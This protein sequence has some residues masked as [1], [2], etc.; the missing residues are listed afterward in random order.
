MNSN[1]NGQ[2]GN[3][4]QLGGSNMMDSLKNNLMTM[5]MFKNMNHTEA[6][7][8]NDMWVMLY[9]FIASQFVDFV[10]KCIP[11]LGT[12]AH[13]MYLNKLEGLKQISSIAI[14]DIIDNKTKTSSITIKI[15]INDG[16]NII[17]QSLLDYITNNKQTSHIGYINKNF[18]LNEMGVIAISEDVYAVM[19]E[20]NVTEENEVEKGSSQR[21]E[22]YSFNKDGTEL[23][24]FLENIKN[25]YVI[26]MNNKL[27]N[28]RYYFNLHPCNAVVSIE[29][30]KDYSRLPSDFVFVMKKFQTNRKFSNIFGEDIDII[31]KRVRFFLKNKDWYDKKG[32]PYTLGLLLS[33]SPGTGKTSTI[34]C[35]TNE[36]N[37]HIINVNLNNDITKTQLDNLFYNENINVINME[38]KQNESYCIPFD[39]RIYV[40]EDVDCQSDIVKQRVEAPHINH[41]YMPTDDDKPKV[42]KPVD[43]LQMDLSFLLNLLDG[44]LETP[45]RILIMT[46]NEPDSLDSA[47]IRPGRIDVIAK[48]LKCSHKTI[49]Q[50]FEFFYDVKLTQS[51]N[52]YIDQFE[53]RSVTPAELGKIMFENINDIQSAFESFNKYN[54]IKPLP[55]LLDNEECVNTQVCDKTRVE[56]VTDEE[57]SD[58]PL[59]EIV[60][61]EKYVTTKV[62][63]KPNSQAGATLD[64]KHFRECN[65]NSLVGHSLAEKYTNYNNN[66]D[67]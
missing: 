30:V 45:G 10:M 7:G 19:I 16:D 53:S 55:S 38:T 21:I 40:L 28:D 5:M 62:V 35:L 31:R 46:S 67:V 36:T 57:D 32:I 56:I 51:Q 18:V 60:T 15:G 20:N 41:R 11:I 1:P 44:I 48:F 17:G 27:G 63:S 49:K 37:R 2:Y 42:E 29:G 47:L 59:E 3:S 22:I 66:C 24:Q 39:Q 58:N 6:K 4:Q 26:N 33:G 23:R 50:M 13:K 52:E 61:S 8:N 43:T 12:K 64:Y 34:K 65:G 54:T 9:I 14:N 25:K